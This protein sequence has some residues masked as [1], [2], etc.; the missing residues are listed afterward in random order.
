[1]VG[2]KHLIFNQSCE[3]RKAFEYRNVG[4][5][6]FSDIN[7]VFVIPKRINCR[8]SETKPCKVNEE[9]CVCQYNKKI[10]SSLVNDCVDESSKI[11]RAFTCMA[12]I[13]GN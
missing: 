12:G 5:H 1:M 9:L 2:L 11:D 10:Y 8:F 4:L 13:S 7:I 6:K 3:N